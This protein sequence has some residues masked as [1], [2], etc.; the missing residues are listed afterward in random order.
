MDNKVF[1][2][3]EK[4]KQDNLQLY[5][6]YKN[7]HHTLDFFKGCI[8]DSVVVLDEMSQIWDVNLDD[9]YIDVEY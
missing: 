4:I 9:Y 1:K 6:D 7:G 2:L 5:E 3:A 8:I